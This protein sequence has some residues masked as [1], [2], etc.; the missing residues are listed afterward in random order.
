MSIDDASVA[1]VTTTSRS[2]PVAAHADASPHGR[3]HRKALTTRQV[4]P[5][6]RGRRVSHARCAS[7]ASS[8]AFF[9]RTCRQ[10]DFG[11]ATKCA[12]A[13]ALERASRAAT[14]SRV[15]ND[16]RRA[17]YASQQ[18]AE[19][20]ATLRGDALADACEHLVSRAEHPSPYV[21]RKALKLIAKCCDGS[22]DR[23]F[24]REMAKHS[25]RVRA[26]RAHAGPPHPTKGDSVHAAVREAAAEAMGAIFGGA[27][28]VHV[29][30]GGGS[31]RIEGFGD[32][33]TTG[34]WATERERAGIHSRS[35]SGDGDDFPSYRTTPTQGPRPGKLDAPLEASLQSTPRLNVDA[36]GPGVKWKPLRPPSPEKK[37]A[38]AASA[39]PTTTRSTAGVDDFLGNFTASPSRAST[40]AVEEK[41]AT[42]SHSRERSASS[43]FILEGS[44]EKRAIDKLCTPSGVRLA[45]L[46]GDLVEFLRT[47]AHLN[48]QGVVIA[49]SERLLT[50]AGGDEAWRRAYRAVCVVEHAAASSTR[51]LADVFANSSAL[52]LLDDVANDANAHAQLRQK[53]QAVAATLRAPR[54]ASID[55]ASPVSNAPQPVDLFAQFGDL[56][57]APPSASPSTSAGNLLDDFFAAPPPPPSMTTAPLPPVAPMTGPGLAALNELPPTSEE[58]RLKNT[59]AFDFVGDLLK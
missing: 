8:D 30:V 3:L 31:G 43:E 54:G 51:W 5:G 27:K 1:R 41:I 48:A 2:R 6:A 40:S 57:V 28:D 22:S 18:L 44:E 10:R 45:P 20:A 46:E 7:N 37:R 49:L 38:D 50:Y 14:D 33:A 53:A 56:S 19:L 55:V 58:Q 13:R 52:E 4:R 24:A 9:A 39:A 12:R 35:T 25:G 23:A 16:V 42:A 47:G 34:N 26:L 15:V 21:R 36:S 32:R 29:A 11:S 17:V 59:H